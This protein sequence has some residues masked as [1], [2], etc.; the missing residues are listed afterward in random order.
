MSDSSEPTGDRWA[1]LRTW[2][3]CAGRG[4]SGPSLV[5]DVARLLAERD[6]LERRVRVE[7]RKRRARARWQRLVSAQEARSHLEWMDARERE[8]DELAAVLRELVDTEGE[9]RG[10]IT[11]SIG[12]R[13]DLLDTRNALIIRARRALGEETDR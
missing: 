12:D 3:R 4:R 7:R 13:R 8:R 9:V 11:R 10:V 2:V 5:E 6:E 1:G